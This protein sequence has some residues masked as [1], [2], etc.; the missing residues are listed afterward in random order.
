MITRCLQPQYIRQQHTQLVAMKPCGRC[1]NCRRKVV[2][3]RQGQAVCENQFPYYQEHHEPF[4]RHFLNLTYAETPLT[5]PRKHKLG[6][7]YLP[8]G[9]EGI[10]CGPWAKKKSIVRRNRY[11]GITTHQGRPCWSDN[12]S[13]LTDREIRR[14]QEAYYIERLGWS[15]A[16]LNQFLKGDYAPEQTLRHKDMTKMMNYLTVWWKRNMPQVPFR[17][18]TAGE[19]GDA[20]GRPHYH[21]MLWGYPLELIHKI[22]DYWDEQEGAG[23][24]KPTLN[25]AETRGESIAGDRAATYQA[26]DLVKSKHHYLGTPGTFDIEP[27]QVAGSRKPPIGDGAYHWWLKNWIYPI[28]KEAQK[29][30]GNDDVMIARTVVENYSVIHLPIRG[31]EQSFPTMP[32]WR[33]MVKRDLGIPDD[34]VKNANILREEDEHNVHN[35]IK[36]NVDGLGD[37]YKQY[38]GELRERADETQS[39]ERQ[40]I[41]EKRARLIAAGKIRPNDGVRSDGISQGQ[42]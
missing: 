8:D 9:S 25:E 21:L 34:A 42:P 36:E 38:L 30:F 20:N 41:A 11:S 19:Y 23:H 33:N 29:R 12:M 31:R 26:K 13:P 35:L 14:E 32:R 28:V 5:V 1:Y 24:I 10:Y 15:Y 17:Y 40:R 37:E 6:R 3:M 2:R 4:D 39:R 18:L 7:A 27:P 22:Y 16:Q